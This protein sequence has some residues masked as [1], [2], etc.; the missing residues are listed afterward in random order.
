MECDITTS[1]VSHIGV[2]RLFPAE[3][4]APCV[5]FQD[6]ICNEELG[7]CF[8]VKIY[9]IIVCTLLSDFWSCALVMF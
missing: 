7:E 9:G 5:V 8:D 1:V 2:V 4:I 6:F 3:D